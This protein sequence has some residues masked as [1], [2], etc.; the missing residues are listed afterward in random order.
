MAQ[1][2]DLKGK[3]LFKQDINAS[4]LAR[5]SDEVG[6]A[7]LDERKVTRLGQKSVDSHYLVGEIT[8]PQEIPSDEY[9]EAL[10]NLLT[11]E[12]DSELAGALGYV[13]CITM[14][15]TIEEYLATSMMVKDEF[16]HARVCY[17][18][19][20]HLGVDVEARIK[21]FDFT[22]RVDEDDLGT[23]RAAG[24]ARVNIFYY[25]INDWYDFISFN[26][27]MDRGAGHQLE[28]ILM[29]SYRPWARVMEGIFKEEM[30]H[31]A[32]GDN[33][34]KRLA[35]DP[36]TKPKMQAGIDRWFPRTMNIFG[37]ANTPKNRLYRELGLK[38]RD[39]QE[40]REAFAT[41][42]K[43]R[44]DEFGLQMPDWQ[45]D[46]GKIPEEAVFAAG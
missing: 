42:V 39:N 18:L 23:T 30:F 36:E 4:I 5:M 13:S 12:A 28:D 26:F 24:D 15:P 25:P 44:L 20:E 32:H 6:D 46:W 9:R 17:K 40:V 37:R 35:A 19:L 27:C 41:E 38:V 45:P 1:A 16:R 2:T 43:Q 11:Q 7:D 21:S 10:T 31:I 14:S 34:V 22:L 3:D 29:S 33:W 8:G